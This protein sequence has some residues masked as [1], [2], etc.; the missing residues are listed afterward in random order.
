[1]DGRDGA[2]GVVAVRGDNLHGRALLVVM[3]STIADL[4]FLSTLEG[5]PQ[6]PHPPAHPAPHTALARAFG[7]LSEASHC[8][9]RSVVSRTISVLF[10]VWPP[11]FMHVA[12]RDGTSRGVHPCPR[13]CQDSAGDLNMTVGLKVRHPPRTAPLSRALP[14]PLGLPS[15]RAP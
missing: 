7:I 6:P 15:L 9:A 13:P 5:T 12:W 11:I 4:H 8:C 10:Q 1:M 3:M 2:A 14:C